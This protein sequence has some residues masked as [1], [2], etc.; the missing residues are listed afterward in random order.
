M[1][2][3]VLVLFIGSFAWG[4]DAVMLFPFNRWFALGCALAS[5]GCF[6]AARRAGK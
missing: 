1:R 2:P 6:C 4:A 5:C 3:E